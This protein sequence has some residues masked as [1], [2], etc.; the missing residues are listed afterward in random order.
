VAL[1]SEE[2]ART[3]TLGL[4]AGRPFVWVGTIGV[5]FVLALIRSLRS[6]SLR[7]HSVRLNRLRQFIGPYRSHFEAS[8]CFLS[9]IIRTLFEG[10]K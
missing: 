6:L 4:R 9:H 7:A 5:L 1:I 8:K 2:F 10:P 3:R